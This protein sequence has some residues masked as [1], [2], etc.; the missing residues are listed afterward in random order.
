MTRHFL[1][2]ALTAALFAATPAAAQV[3][4]SRVW[5][6]HRPDGIR[7]AGGTITITSKA[8]AGVRT[9]TTD[10][11][12]RYIVTNLAPGE[13]TILTELAGFEPTKQDACAAPISCSST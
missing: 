1:T 9:V 4:E 7:P 11:D 5:P 2:L 10:A 6:R 3:T 13:Y 12:G 8:A